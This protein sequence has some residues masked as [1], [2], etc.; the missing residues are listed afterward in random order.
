MVIAQNTSP[1]WMAPIMGPL[2]A[3]FCMGVGIWWLSNRNAKQDAKL[4][5]NK[6]EQDE[7]NKA[8]LATQIEATRIMTAALEASKNV[9]A[10]NAIVLEKASR[11]LDKHKC[12]DE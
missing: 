11:S 7:L 4:D 2:G 8:T 5:E 10:Q 9:L 12:H 6:K 3:L 1:D